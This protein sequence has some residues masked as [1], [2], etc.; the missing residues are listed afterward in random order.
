M[1]PSQLLAFV[2]V[3]MQELRYFILCRP[4]LNKRDC[5]KTEA[6]LGVIGIEDIFRLNNYRD[7]GYFQ[8]EINWII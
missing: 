2:F 6:L 5:C 7:K 1:D 4:C 3:Y 8:G